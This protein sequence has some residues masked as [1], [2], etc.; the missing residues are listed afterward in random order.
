MKFAM[1]R[2]EL[3]AVYLSV[4]LCGGDGCVTE[5]FLDD[6]QIRPASKQMGGKG[7]AELVGMDGPLNASTPSIISDQLP[8]TSRG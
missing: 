1:K 7:V 4:D 8:D 6:A 5:H 3:T 2:L